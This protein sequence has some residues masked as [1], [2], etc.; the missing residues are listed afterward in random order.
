MKILTLILFLFVTGPASAEIYKWTD[1]EGQ[2]HYDENPGEGSSGSV[3]VPR[4]NKAPATPAPSAKQRLENIRKW[5]D[6]R[7]KER[8]TEKRRKAEQDAKRVK[9]E[10]KC[11]RKRNRL[12]DLERGGRRYRL[13]ENGQRRF[14]SD[15]EIDSRKNDARAYL[16]KHCR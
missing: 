3:I 11:H 4:Q 9:Q 10:E 6:A 16:E 12:T 15:Q 7:Q 2:V 14:L 8:E 13:D 5:T 1:E